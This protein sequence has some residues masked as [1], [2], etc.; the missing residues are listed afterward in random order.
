MA[1]FID[2][3]KGIIEE[4]RANGGRM[5]GRWEGRPL[6]LLTTTGAKSGQLRISPVTYF[7]DGG[8]YYV[9]ASKGGSD[10]HPDWYRNL[11][12]NPAVSVE[13]GEEKFEAIATVLPSAERD[14]IYAR[15]TEVMPQFADYQSGTS[16][17][18]PVV[19]L[20]RTK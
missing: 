6:L 11:V 17:T 7:E 10:A 5:T 2:R 18:I 19:A 9:F 8:R 1:S 20:T 15:Q 14:A 13:M 12:A 3:N 4:Y 16:R